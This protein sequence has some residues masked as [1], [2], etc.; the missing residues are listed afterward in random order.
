MNIDTTKKPI[1]LRCTF[2][3]QDSD[4]RISHVFINQIY[5]MLIL[6]SYANLTSLIS[7]PFHT[8]KCIE[9]GTSNFSYFPMEIA[10]D[11]YVDSLKM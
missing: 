9:S 2:N 11:L 8:F 7:Y 5:F 6:F 4:E 1:L 10:D 3:L